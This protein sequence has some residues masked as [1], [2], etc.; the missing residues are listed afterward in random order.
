M[1]LSYIYFFVD[2]DDSCC[3]SYRFPHRAT[4]LKMAHHK[5]YDITYMMHFDFISNLYY[6]I[7]GLKKYNRRN[8]AKPRP[9][10]FPKINEA[11]TPHASLL[12]STCV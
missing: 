4:M 10:A 1:L 5:K 7:K 12:E 2:G 9:T 8:C 6:G 3:A 11:E